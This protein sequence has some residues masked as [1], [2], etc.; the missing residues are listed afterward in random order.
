MWQLVGHGS[1]CNMLLYIYT[2][3]M[4]QLVGHG[5]YCNMLLFI[6]TAVMWQLVG[7]DSS[8]GIT[9][10]HR[11][12]GPRGRIPSR[13]PLESTLPSVQWKPHHFHRTKIA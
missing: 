5:S 1:Y 11:L 6:Y 13:P 10:G 3:V 12:D 4:W 9:N 2:A 8:I 7:H